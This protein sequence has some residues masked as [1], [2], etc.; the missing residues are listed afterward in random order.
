MALIL[1]IDTALEEASVC[2]SED[3]NVLANKKNTGK[4]I[5]LPGYRWRS[6]NY[7]LKLD[8]IRPPF[9][10]SCCCGPRILH[11]AESRHGYRQGMCY[12]LGV[13]LITQSTLLLIAQ[14]VKKKWT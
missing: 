1:S 3:E 13:P 14:R 11:R 12:A 2:I 6:K 9:G 8:L 4:W 7:L 10:D 5:M